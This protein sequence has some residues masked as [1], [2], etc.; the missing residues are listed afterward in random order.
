MVSVAA[1]VVL[2]QRGL[3]QVAQPVI[4]PRCV[5][6]A[7]TTTC[8]PAGSSVDLQR[9]SNLATPYVELLQEFGL[10]P[11][12]RF[13]LTGSTA[14]PATYVRLAL[15]AEFDSPAAAVNRQLATTIAGPRPCASCDQL[16]RT[17]V[18]QAR[19]LLTWWLLRQVIGS[20]PVRMTRAQASWLV[21]DQASQWVLANYSAIAN[22]NRVI[23]IPMPFA[24]R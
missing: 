1:A 15:P 21:S 4:E 2:A 8:A 17:S 23:R 3:G 16:V 24:T 11:P 13:F 9:V 20:V 18:A 6:T 5:Y 12:S 10:N 22:C 7:T 14:A 19:A